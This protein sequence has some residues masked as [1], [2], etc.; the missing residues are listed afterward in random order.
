MLAEAG[1]HDTSNNVFTAS[2][3]GGPVNPNVFNPGADTINE[4]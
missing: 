2:G 3:D 1:G 4:L